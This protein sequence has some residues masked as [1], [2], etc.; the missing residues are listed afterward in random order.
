MNNKGLT[1]E[2]FRGR[3]E[4]T[5]GGLSSGV[6]EITV[7]GLGKGSEMFAPD[8]RA[9][10]FRLESHVPGCLRLVPVDDPRAGNCAGP[11]FGGNYA[12]TSD[13]R[14]SKVCERLLGHRF[15]GAV[16]IHDRYESWKDYEALS[17]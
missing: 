10:A 12:A 3:F 14:F 15:Y 5:N 11:M 17:R 16:A 6:T 13:S 2:V 9:P 8:S 7:V 4:A 1:L